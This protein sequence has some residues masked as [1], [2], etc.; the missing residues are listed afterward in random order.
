MIKTLRGWWEPFR[1]LCSLPFVSAV[2]PISKDFQQH[3]EPDTLPVLVLVL[4]DVSR[5]RQSH[6]GTEEG[7]PAI[8]ADREREESRGTIW[9]GPVDSV[10]A[11]TELKQ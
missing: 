4:T 8:K 1:P 3:Q 10:A 11:A 9:L 2:S 5:G 7:R 6:V